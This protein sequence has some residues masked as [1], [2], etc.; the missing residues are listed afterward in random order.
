[1]LLPHWLNLLAPLLTTAV[2]IFTI[3]NPIGN[4]PVFL[5]LATGKR[6]DDLAMARACAVT[7]AVTLLLATWFGNGILQLFGISQGAFQ[8]AGGLIL[9]L[10]GLS[11]LRSKPS[12]MHRTSGNEDSSGAGSIAGV[13][14]LGI[15]MMA[16]PG[17][18]S[19][20]IGSP[21][22]RTANGRLDLTM[23][24][25]VVSGLVFVIFALSDWLNSRL[26]SASL[27]ILTKVMGLLLTSIAVQMLFSGV[28]AEF[29]PS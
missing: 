13:V 24:V 21:L 23:I 11:M 27:E 19:L 8:A 3:T 18:I 6:R 1:M 16:G 14:P 26:S 20:V 29:F 7:V 25:L 12:D 4:I 28:Q 9:V 15:P 22:G 17:T 5:A 2:G 10:I